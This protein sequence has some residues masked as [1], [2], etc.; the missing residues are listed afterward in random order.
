MTEEFLPVGKISG[1]FGIKGWVK[2]FSFTEPRSNILEYTPLFIKIQGEWKEIEVTGGKAQGKGVVM[3]FKNVTDRNQTLSLI[4]AELAIR[5]SQLAPAEDNEYYWTDLIGLEVINEQEQ[6][7]GLVDSLLETG[8]NDVLV[9]KTVQG[10]EILV[11]FVLDV[12]VKSV[13][14]DK[15]RIL[16]DWQIDY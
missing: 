2:V 1:A 7:L 5:K 6:T 3:G 8:A 4:G 16:V 9:V 14:I 13:D 12:I 15:Q 11:P 10:V